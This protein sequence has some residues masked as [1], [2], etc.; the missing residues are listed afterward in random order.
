MTRE[1][2]E[3]KETIIE[4]R[5]NDGTGTQQ[6]VCKFLVN[7]MEIL[8]KQTQEPSG[9][10]ICRQAVLEQINCWIGSGEYR[11]TNATDY[12]NKRIKAL[13]TVNPQ[14]PKTGHP[15]KSCD[16]CEHSDEIDGSNC[17]ECVKDMRNNYSPKKMVEPQESEE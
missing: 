4:M 8:E 6:E 10:L 9:D 1:W 2:Q 16:T 17:Y 5:D 3:L 13:Q 15:Q 7:Y 14:K 11:Y 12:L